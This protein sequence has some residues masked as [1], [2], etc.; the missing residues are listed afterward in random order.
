MKKSQLKPLI[1]K[2]LREVYKL[3]K[4]GNSGTL[5]NYEIEF[6]GITIPGICKSTDLVYVYTNIEYDSSSDIPAKGISNP[7]ESGDFNIIDYD[8]GAIS[9]WNNGMN[10]SKKEYD[11]KQLSLEQQS[12]VKKLVGEYLDEHEENIRDI[13]SSSSTSSE[14]DDYPDYEPIEY[15]NNDTK[16]N[17]G[18]N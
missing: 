13:V 18:G 10:D 5:N 4:N 12:I 6:D 16:T 17:L 15:H 11:I 8:V 9:V 14:H 1:K 2:I 7:P 3:Q